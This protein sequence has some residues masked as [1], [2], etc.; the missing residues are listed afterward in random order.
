MKPYPSLACFVVLT[1]CTP[2]PDKRAAPDL[3]LLGGYRDAAD[4][5]RIAGETAYTNQ[6]LDHTL[7]LVAC[8]EDAENLGV[9]ITQTGAYEVGRRA[10]YILF[11]VPN[12]AA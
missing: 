1:A 3:I 7:D 2:A 5:C 12:A 8:P 9:F 10:G 4:A 11:S 6:F